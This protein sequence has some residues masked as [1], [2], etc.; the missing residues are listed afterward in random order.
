MPGQGRK[1]TDDDLARMA[2]EG[3][4]SKEI[5]DHFGVHV[6]HIQAH[7]RRLGIKFHRST[8]RHEQVIRDMFADGKTFDEIARHLNVTTMHLHK[9]MVKLGIEKPGSKK[10]KVVVLAEKKTPKTSRE[11]ENLDRQ[12]KEF[13]DVDRQASQVLEN[14]ELLAAVLAKSCLVY[15]DVVHSILKN[16]DVRMSRCLKGGYIEFVSN[17]HEE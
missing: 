1:F 7:G 8:D 10:V 11:I 15:P 6:T 13:E 17:I 14:R 5:A 3:L 4:S 12:K 9:R 2:K 16:T